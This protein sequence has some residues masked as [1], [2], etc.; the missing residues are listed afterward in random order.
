MTEIVDTLLAEMGVS[1]RWRLK[2]SYPQRYRVQFR[3]SDFAFIQRI[4]ADEGIFFFFGPPDSAASE[5]ST[6]TAAVGDPDVAIFSDH[7]GGYLDIDGSPALVYRAGSGA[8][9]LARRENHV[10]EFS[11]RHATRALSVALKDYDFTRPQHDLSALAGATE[12]A[13]REVFD[14]EADGGAKRPERAVADVLLDRLRRDAQVARGSTECRRLL[15]GHRFVLEE[16]HAA[17]LNQTYVII[18]VHHKGR[19]RDALKPGQETYS[20]SRT[21]PLASRPGRAGREPSTE[22][23]RSSSRRSAHTGPPRGASLAT[24]KGMS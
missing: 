23:G 21:R 5:T 4:V 2:D 15:P 12:R 1:C 11:F 22:T 24:R 20:G 10:G 9:A 6:W 16:H 17:E 19:A 7:T 3:E 8:S 13:D 14:H 18:R